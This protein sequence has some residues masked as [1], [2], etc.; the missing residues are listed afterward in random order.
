[1]RYKLILPIFLF[2]AVVACIFFYLRLSPQITC[3]GSKELNNRSFNS[4]TINFSSIAEPIKKDF[5][6]YLLSAFGILPNNCIYYKSGDGKI[7]FNTKIDTPN[8]NKFVNKIRFNSPLETI[9][10][11]NL[12]YQNS[13]IE[14]LENGSDNEK[15]KSGKYYE[16]KPI[17]FSDNPD[18]LYI[19]IFNNSSVSSFPLKSIDLIYAIGD[20]PSQSSKYTNRINYF[21]YLSAF[22]IISFIFWFFNKYNLNYQFF[23]ILFKKYKNLFLILFCMFIPLFLSI[24]F[25]TKIYTNQINEIVFYASLIFIFFIFVFD[26]LIYISKSLDLKSLKFFYFFSEH[27]HIICIVSLFLIFI[28]GAF[29]LYL[30]AAFF[31]FNF[32]FSLMIICFFDLFS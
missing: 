30:G 26:L 5:K 20:L 31:A 25:N 28:L 9:S 6:F 14:I 21:V 1:M 10:R 15:I 27:L 18:S 11:V 16:I 19:Y 7:I 4:Y 3:E 13:L 23:L 24:Y 29:G 8:V 32:L 22:I 12:K 2:T 17:Y